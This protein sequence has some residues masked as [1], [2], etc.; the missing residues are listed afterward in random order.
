MI[1]PEEAH[2]V[3][4]YDTGP[5]RQARALK[6]ASGSSRYNPYHAEVV[7]QLAWQVLPDMPHKAPECIGIVTPYAAQRDYI[8]GLL[9]GT[10][11]EV[12]VR[13]GTIHAFQGLEFDALILDTVESPGLKIAPFLRGGWGADAMRLL[14]VAVSRARHKLLIVANMPYISEEPTSFILPQM[15]RLACQKKRI[16]VDLEN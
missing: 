5:S 4:L 8:K 7:K 1:G 2:A 10:E 6:P 3:V 9:K 13:V 15:M 16:P 12:F 14:N 11:L